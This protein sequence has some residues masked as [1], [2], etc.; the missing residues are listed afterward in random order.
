M[1][2]ASPKLESNADHGFQ[3]CVLAAQVAAEII[4]VKIKQR[5][6]QEDNGAVR[7]TAKNMHQ[8]SRNGSQSKDLRADP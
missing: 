8:A 3:L 2:T 4:V 7:W 6:R 5:I 1:W